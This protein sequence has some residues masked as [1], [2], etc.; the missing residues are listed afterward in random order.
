MLRSRILVILSAFLVVGCPAT[1]M[2]HNGDA[3]LQPPPKRAY[4]S[5]NSEYLTAVRAYNKYVESY[6]ANMA[7]G[8][9]KKDDKCRAV[10]ITK[11]FSIPNPPRITT[12]DARE[13]VGI[14]LDYID[15]IKS[16]VSAHNAVVK[17]QKEL[18][19]TLCPKGR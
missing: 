16:S 12:D 6:A 7:N 2:L 1:T 10:I 9:E 3:E 17:E 18:F 5:T 19:E 8:P 4:Y 11:P 15:S 14:L 13:Q